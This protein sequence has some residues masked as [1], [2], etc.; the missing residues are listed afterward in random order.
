MPVIGPRGV[1]AL[2]AIF[3]LA[4]SLSALLITE[5]R[6]QLGSGHLQGA[7]LCLAAPEGWP[8]LRCSLVQLPALHVWSAC[9]CL[10]LASI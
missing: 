1:F 5:D 7:P 8:E 2:T 10:L 3:P 9:R 6:V 4:V